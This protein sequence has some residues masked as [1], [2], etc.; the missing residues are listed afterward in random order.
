MRRTLALMV[1]TLALLQAWSAIGQE[2]QDT[3]S[4][5]SEVDA[6][7][8]LTDFLNP[9]DRGSDND[10]DNDSDNVTQPEDLVDTDLTTTATQNAFLD[11]PVNKSLVDTDLTT[12]ATQNAF[13]EQP[14]NESLIDT[15]APGTLTQMEFLLGQTVAAPTPFYQKGQMMG[16][17]GSEETSADQPPAFFKKHQMM[18]T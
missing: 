17:G 1:A 18:G 13:L 5:D 15:T 3:L 11:V 4:L 8:A 6:P 9:L 12:T 14:F 10:S 16:S 2:M 7:A